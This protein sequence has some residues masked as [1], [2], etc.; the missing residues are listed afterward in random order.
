MVLTVLLTIR[1]FILG[2][3]PVLPAWGV[4]MEGFPVLRLE[5]DRGRVGA[6]RLGPLRALN[7][8]FCAP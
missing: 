1:E 5:E 3:L 7:A 8:T 6:W 2:V 4:V